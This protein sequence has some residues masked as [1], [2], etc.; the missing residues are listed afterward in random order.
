MSSHLDLNQGL[1]SYKDGTLTNWVTEGLKIKDQ[2]FLISKERLYYNNSFLKNQVKILKIFWLERVVTLHFHGLQRTR[3][4]FYATLH[5]CFRLAGL[6]GYAPSATPWKGV[7]TTIAPKP[8]CLSYK[9]YQVNTGLSEILEVA[10]FE[11][12][13]CCLQ[14]SHSTSWV[15]PPLKSTP[16]L[17]DHTKGYMVKLMGNS[18]QIRKDVLENV[19]LFTSIKVNNTISYNIQ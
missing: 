3:H 1:P 10:G 7:E 2:L 6:D 16:N 12:A 18:S 19:V 14:S 13:T 5:T 4:Y 9:L 8:R 11:P 17:K 15:I